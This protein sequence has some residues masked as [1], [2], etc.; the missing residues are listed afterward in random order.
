MIIFNPPTP[1]ARRVRAPL[2]FIYLISY[3]VS[4]EGGKGEGQHIRS[5]KTPNLCLRTYLLL[6]TYYLLLTYL[7]AYLLTYYLLTYLLL[8]DYLLLTSYYTCLFSLL[9][10]FIP[11]KYISEQQSQISK[12][13]TNILWIS[14]IRE[15]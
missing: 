3:N 14:H 6:T 12:Q 9:I 1:T 5:R 8:T 4:R 15:R 11:W 7:L 2:H 13:I 10:G